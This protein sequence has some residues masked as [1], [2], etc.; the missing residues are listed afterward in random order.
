MR[1]I[2]TRVLLRYAN[3]RRTAM[4]SIEQARKAKETLRAQLRRPTWLRGVGIGQD[5]H[6]SHLVRV[7]VAEMNEEVRTLPKAVMGVPVEVDVTGD[8]ETQ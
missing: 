4:I 3:L 2:T 8:F 6:G 1:A 5:S 7:M